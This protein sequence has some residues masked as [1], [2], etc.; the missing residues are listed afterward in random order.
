MGRKQTTEVKASQEKYCFSERCVGGSVEKYLVILSLKDCM[1]MHLDKRLSKGCSNIL[2]LDKYGE[3]SLVIRRGGYWGKKVN[4]NNCLDFY[5]LTLPLKSLATCR[6]SIFSSRISGHHIILVHIYELGCLYFKKLITKNVRKW[7]WTAV[8]TYCSY[9][10]NTR[11]IPCYCYHLI[12]CCNDHNRCA[13]PHMLHYP[14]AQPR[15]LR[16]F[17]RVCWK[18][19]ATDKTLWP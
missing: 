9:F 14:Y 6:C 7:S 16:S 1:M 3:E 18:P 15:L 2:S 17:G 5:D 11:L 12:L 19:A 13:C 4:L 8:S 10:W